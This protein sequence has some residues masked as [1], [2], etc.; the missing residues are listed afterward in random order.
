MKSLWDYLEAISYDSWREWL[1]RLIGCS[2]LAVALFLLVLLILLLIGR[3][4]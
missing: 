4:L 1:D 3:S 2:V